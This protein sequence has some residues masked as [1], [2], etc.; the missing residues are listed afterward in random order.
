[1]VSLC[2]SKVLS[3]WLEE[4]DEAD[5]LDRTREL[6]KRMLATRLVTSESMWIKMLSKQEWKKH[7]LKFQPRTRN[8]ETD[9][10]FQFPD[11][12]V[13]ESSDEWN[14]MQ[15]VQE[16]RL[17]GIQ[18]R[19]KTDSPEVYKLTAGEMPQLGADFF[20]KRA[21]SAREKKAL[22][23]SKLANLLF[24][25]SPE[26]LSA[27]H[28]FYFGN[29][30]NPRP[31]DALG[32]K[33]MA[34]GVELERVVDG[35]L[36][37]LFP[38]STI[39]KSGFLC[40]YDT[41]TKRWI[42]SSNDGYFWLNRGTPEEIQTMLEI[43][44]SAKTNKSEVSYYSPQLLFHMKVNPYGIKHCLFVMWKLR[45]YAKHESG[46]PAEYEQQLRMYIVPWSELTWKALMQYLDLFYAKEFTKMY[47]RRFQ[48][49]KIFQDYTRTWIQLHPTRG[50]FAAPYAYPLRQISACA[51]VKRVNPMMEIAREK[52]FKKA[53]EK[54]LLKL[55]NVQLGE[56]GLAMGD[57]LNRK[58]GDNHDAHFER[59]KKLV[60]EAP[61]LTA[62]AK[63]FFPTKKRPR[64]TK[65]GEA[66][67]T[68]RPAKRARIKKG[69]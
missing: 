17:V 6:H 56:A 22:S 26:E 20:K 34:E 61:G 39:G 16:G 4:D 46:T 53:R 67:A 47:W 49:Q 44:V 37:N 11:E 25:K 57:M 33:R 63:R 42:G 7:G 27:Y 2:A 9:P 3:Q 19:R 65:L 5:V 8:D 10:T 30:P 21:E 50:C 1:M 55:L 69:E 29:G 38:E 54:Q 43:K 45:R 59:V 68:K 58:A 40:K 31:P 18:E 28:E 32:E 15:V 64:Q 48:M 35:A 24:A 51:A 60:R 52:I 13:L 36:L 41:E 12:E 23:S 62:F 14:A 66:S